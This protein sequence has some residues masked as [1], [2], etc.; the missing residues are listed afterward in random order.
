MKK[1]KFYQL[2]FIS[3]RLRET[4]IDYLKNAS[5]RYWKFPF[6]LKICAFIIPKNELLLKWEKSKICYHW[7]FFKYHFE[8]RGS[9][10]PKNMLLSRLKKCHFVSSK[11][12]KTRR[13][14]AWWNP[15]S[16]KLYCQ[17]KKYVCFFIGFILRIHFAFAKKQIWMQHL[18]CVM[19][20]CI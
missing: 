11:M 13:I 19:L 12:C 1:I 6:F 3:V 4:K 9:I 16:L 15:K 20:H 5:N 8:M 7:S 18:V 14:N 17:A 10:F 2:Y